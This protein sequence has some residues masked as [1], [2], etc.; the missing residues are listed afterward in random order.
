IPLEAG[1]LGRAISTSKGCYVGQEVV[2]RILHRGGGR[3]AKRVATL[4][5]EMEAGLE[6]QAGWNLVVDD[7]VVGRTTSVARS[8][9]GERFIGIGVVRREAAEIGRRLSLEGQDGIAEITGFTS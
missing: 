5:F 6:P 3:V 8:L 1:L 2:I 9:T 4:A 7:S